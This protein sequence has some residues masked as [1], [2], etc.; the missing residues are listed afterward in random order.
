MRNKRPIQG[1]DAQNPDRTDC[2][3][4]GIMGLAEFIGRMRYGCT[5]DFVLIAEI[6]ST[7][8]KK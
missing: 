5:G 4:A 6:G 7:V 1:M 8:R 2:H 3:D